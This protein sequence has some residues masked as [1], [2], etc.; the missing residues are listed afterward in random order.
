MRVGDL[1]D[2]YQYVSDTQEIEA[3]LRH[4]GRLDLMCE[5]GCLFV[6]VG[7]GE[8]EEVWGCEPLVPWL[9]TTLDKLL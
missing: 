7:E 5:Y 8:Y 1:S 3:V 6:L 4:I 9:E 2:R